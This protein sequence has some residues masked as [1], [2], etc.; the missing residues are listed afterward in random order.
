MVS[1]ASKKKP[2]QLGQS[3]MLVVQERLVV[4]KRIPFPPPFRTQRGGGGGSKEAGEEL[5]CGHGVAP[6]RVLPFS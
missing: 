3:Y 1:E 5:P 2:Q 6:I 4:E